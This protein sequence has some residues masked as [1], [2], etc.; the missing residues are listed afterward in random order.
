[1]QSASVTQC[2]LGFEALVGDYSRLPRVYL[3]ED[4]ARDAEGLNVVQTVW[5]EFICDDPAGE[6]LHD[7]AAKVYRIR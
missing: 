3:A 4:Y 2:S 6:A 5:A 1:M 7:T